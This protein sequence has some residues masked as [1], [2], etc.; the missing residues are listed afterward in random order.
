MYLFN[1]VVKYFQV[2]EQKDLEVWK[3]YYDWQTIDPW[4]VN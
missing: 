2:L 4:R 3:N 1:C